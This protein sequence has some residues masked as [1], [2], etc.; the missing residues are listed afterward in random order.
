MAKKKSVGKQSVVVAQWVRPAIEH[1]HEIPLVGEARS[2][3]YFC[4]LFVQSLFICSTF[5]FIFNTCF[6]LFCFGCVFFSKMESFGLGLSF[7]IFVF[8]LVSV[9]FKNGFQKNILSSFN[10]VLIWFGYRGIFFLSPAISLWLCEVGIV[11]CV[12]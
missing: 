6:S 10:L 8:N 1:A 3:L 2:G 9:K 12:G 4:G 11:S 7:D 5:C